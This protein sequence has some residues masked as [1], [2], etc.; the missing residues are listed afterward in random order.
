MKTFGV[1]IVDRVDLSVHVV[2]PKGE[3]DKRKLGEPGGAAHLGNA[4]YIRVL[5]ILVHHRDKDECRNGSKERVKSRDTRDRGRHGSL[6]ARD[7]HV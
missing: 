1:F 6:Y 7:I 3:P 5:V 4:D 2:G